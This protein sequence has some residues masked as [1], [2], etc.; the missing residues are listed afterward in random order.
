MTLSNILAPDITNFHT[1]ALFVCQLFIDGNF[2]TGHLV[3]DSQ[4]SDD[5]LITE[6]NLICSHQIP[7]ITTDINIPTQS[8]HW[9]IEDNS[10][11]SLQVIVLD[12]AKSTQFLN[13]PKNQFS[14]YRIFVFTSTDEMD[15]KQTVSALKNSGLNSD[16]NSLVLHHSSTKHSIKVHWI[17]TKEDP[18][19]R[20]ED[21]SIL[22]V[23]IYPN[24]QRHQKQSKA[25]NLF[26]Q[27]FGIYKQ[28][29]EMGIHFMQ[30]NTFSNKL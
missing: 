16:S 27:T 24:F 7:W 2:R 20:S 22:N 9:T 17:V 12:L 3:Y 13:E 23:E 5:R 29:Q 18:A 21:L 15:M 11:Y 26:D 6:T 25:D 1:L 8:S 19:K 10:D 28:L 14:F 4:I 30:G